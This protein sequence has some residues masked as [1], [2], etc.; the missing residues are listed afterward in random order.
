MLPIP[1]WLTDLW[2]GSAPVE[3]ESSFGLHD[4]VERLKAATRRSVFSSMAQ[5]EAV[6]TVSKSRV[7]LQ[8]VIPMVGNS[9]KPFY[10]GRFVE[11]NGKVILTG[12]FSMNRL[13]KAFMALW[14]GGLAFFV[15]L[16]LLSLVR[17]PQKAV[18]PALAG[19]GITAAGVALVWFGKWLSRNDPA[20]LSDVIRGAL[21]AQA[22]VPPARIDTATPRAY[23]SGQPSSAMTLV[24]V[25]L[26]LM[27][28]LCVLGAILGIRSAHTAPNGFAVQYFSNGI[29]R[30]LSGMYGA[31]MLA[32]AFGV[33]RR[34]LLAWRAA[35]VLLAGGWVYSVAEILAMNNPHFD[36]R[37]AIFFSVASLFV[38]IVW[39]RWWYAQRIHF[40]E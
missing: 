32:L 8:R 37:M 13:I 29:S 7:S 14:F 23:S 24:T 3:F 2:L 25:A 20:W 12:R 38:M 34:R 19:V 30:F 11:R 22:G 27:G 40:R 4:S 1:R 15:L 33:Y 28:A 31:V 9:F 16:G 10:R 39:I 17:Q 35:L 5:Q 36:H 6:G 26:A 18:V 21:C